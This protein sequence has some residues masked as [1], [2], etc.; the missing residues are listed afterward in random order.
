MALI[1]AAAPA[2]AQVPAVPDAGRV[3]SLVI[4]GT[5]RLRQEHGLRRVEPEGR[6]ARAALEFA[7]Y[8]AQV[9]RLDHEADG[10]EPSGRAR[11]QGYDYCLVAENIAYEFHSAGFTTSQLADQLL[12][13][14]EHS[15]GHLRN[16]LA[17][18]ATETAVAV[19]RSGRT[20]RYYAVQM[21]GRP[22]S[23]GR[24]S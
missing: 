9:D 24:C 23:D 10:R 1:L 18:D 4:E 19:A 16:M 15:A 3:A 11:A 12:A 2:D 8:M 21:F 22:R 13:G 14:W 5:N 6:L 17:R 20:G 7:A